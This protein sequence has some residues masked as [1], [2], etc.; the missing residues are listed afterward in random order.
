MTE[1]RNT[2]V[3]QRSQ[4][5][6]LTNSRK[7]AYD[8]ESSSYSSQRTLS[9]LS[10]DSVTYVIFGRGAGSLLVIFLFVC[11]VIP[12]VRFGFLVA[13]LGLGSDSLNWDVQFRVLDSVRVLGFGRRR[14]WVA[15][16][17]PGSAHVAAG[18][19]NPPTLGSG[20]LGL[21]GPKVMQDLV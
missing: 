11:F 14:R 16:F 12:K 5:W 7:R 8:R 4:S 6:R 2:S 15:M 3:Q 9:R 13:S 18:P 21:L 20:E 10:V 17:F 19:L 1:A